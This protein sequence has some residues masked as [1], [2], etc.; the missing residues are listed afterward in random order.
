MDWF[1]LN[2]P[3]SRV[4]PAGFRCDGQIR[5]N[6]VPAPSDFCKSCGADLRVTRLRV[7]RVSY[8]D[9]WRLR[10]CKLAWEAEENVPPSAAEECERLEISSG[11]R[12]RLALLYVEALET[13]GY[14]ICG[15]WGTEIVGITSDCMFLYAEASEYAVGFETWL[16][17]A[18]K[19]VSPVCDSD[20]LDPASS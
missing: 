20:E 19:L 13:F 11:S 15:L 2:V 9:V 16:H 17:Y 18:P 7:S 10:I 5:T 6:H 4:L 8:S 14:V 12:E 1:I 3:R